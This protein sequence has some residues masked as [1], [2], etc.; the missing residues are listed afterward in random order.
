MLNIVSYPF[1][2]RFCQWVWQK[3]FRKKELTSR[4]IV[5]GKQSTEKYSPNVIRNQKYTIITFLPKVWILFLFKHNLPV[6]ILL[7]Y[8]S[9]CFINSSNSF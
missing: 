5:I 1:F 3:C 6:I 7:K 4:T 9:R 8:I 2:N